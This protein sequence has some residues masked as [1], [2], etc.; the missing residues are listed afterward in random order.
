MAM[1]QTVLLADADV[2]IDYRESELDILKLVVQHIGR[3]VVLAP[4]LDEV[5]GVIAISGEIAA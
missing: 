4:V 1:G 3:V 5:Q 2:L